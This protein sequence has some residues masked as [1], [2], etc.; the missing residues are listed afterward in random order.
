MSAPTIEKSELEALQQDFQQSQDAVQYAMKRVDI[1]YSE[2]GLSVEDYYSIMEA[3][4]H[5]EI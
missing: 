1:V 3:L 2:G 4:Q 5:A